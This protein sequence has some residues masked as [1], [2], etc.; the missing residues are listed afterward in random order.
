MTLGAV[1]TVGPGFTVKLG[2]VNKGC[3]VGVIAVAIRAPGI[4]IHGST[5]VGDL[6][7]TRHTAYWIG[8]VAV[9]GD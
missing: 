6:A 2:L 1:A 9:S 7:V 3:R 4:N 5:F 8:T